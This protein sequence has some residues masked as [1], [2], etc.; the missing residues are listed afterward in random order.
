VLSITMPRIRQ[1]IRDDV[2]ERAAELISR[3]RGPL[4]MLELATLAGISRATLYREFS[5]RSG[6]E[7]HLRARGVLGAS[8]GTGP[9]TRE[10]MLAGARRAIAAH[11]VLGVTVAQIALESGVG[12]AT[13]YRSFKDRES[14]LRAAFDEV[15]ARQ[16]AFAL[17]SEPDAPLRRTLVALV[18]HLLEF[19][20]REPEILRLIAFGHGAES[21]YVRRLRGGQRSATAQLIQF[22]ARQQELG[23]LRKQAPEQLAGALFG[24]IYVGT[25]IAGGHPSVRGDLAGERLDRRAAEL[26]DVFLHGAAR[27]R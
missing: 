9:A 11:G 2:L 23:R 4:R 16:A 19:A 8:E 7:R 17:L 24:A 25:R 6:L 13:I 26:V 20:E 27:R 14:L 22:L 1:N 18:R 10:R 12:E 5:G 21:R 3:G 15:P